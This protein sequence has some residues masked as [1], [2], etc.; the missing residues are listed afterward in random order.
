MNWSV[1]S[2]DQSDRV[3]IIENHQNNIF[4]DMEECSDHEEC[5]GDSRCINLWCGE[6]KYFAAL[7]E[8]SC[9]TDQF[10]QVNFFY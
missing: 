1:V 7:E 10:C 5:S 6:Q 4:S 3:N 8:M 9:S 2:S